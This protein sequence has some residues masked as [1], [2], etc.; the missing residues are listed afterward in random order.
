MNR[1]SPEAE[2]MNVEHFH[3]QSLF[4]KEDL[5]YSNMLAACPGGDGNPPSKQHCDTLRGNKTLSRNP[6]RAADRIEEFIHYLGDGTIESSDQALN[7]QLGKTVLN[8]NNARF[9]RNRRDILY[10][11]QKSLGKKSIKL[12]GWKRLEMEWG[13]G[14]NGNKLPEYCGIV[15]YY[16]RKKLAVSEKK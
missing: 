1:I 8:L 15:A 10:D 2:D 6:A 12:A 9:V 7:K 5:D 3:P 14:A 13:G 4:P 16:I 11:F